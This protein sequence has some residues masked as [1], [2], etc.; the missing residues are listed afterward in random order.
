LN[1]LEIIAEQ[2]ALLA[3]G[4]GS[5]RHK[6]LED[7]R[8][9]LVSGGFE[10]NKDQ[11]TEDGKS[12]TYTH[13]DPAK[14][15]EIKQAVKSLGFKNTDL[16]A[17]GKPRTYGPSGNQHENFEHANSSPND[18]KTG[19]EHDWVQVAKYKDGRGG[20]S[21]GTSVSLHLRGPA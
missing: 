20:G 16:D 14:A 15:K 8:S 10:V 9:Q 1:I 12:M 3:G 17:K 19:E 7:L 2:T 6:E 13:P 18:W 4:P 11:S 21:R 5:G